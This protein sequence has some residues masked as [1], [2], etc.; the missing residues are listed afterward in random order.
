MLSVIVVDVWEHVCLQFINRADNVAKV[1]WELAMF[2]VWVFVCGILAFA[3]SV[4]S[5]NTRS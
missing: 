1:A 3:L 2:C 5:A 4:S